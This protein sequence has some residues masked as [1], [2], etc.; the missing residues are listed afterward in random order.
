M[1]IKDK[2]L[3]DESHNSPTE[4]A[5]NNIRA[6]AAD[7]SLGDKERKL[8]GQ[9]TEL[10]EIRSSLLLFVVNYGES[11]RTRNALHEIVLSQLEC[12]IE[13]EKIRKNS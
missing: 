6:R 13:I 1:S 11:I 5:I 10:S 2:S 7:E 4:E 9:L 8:R 3:S 12:E